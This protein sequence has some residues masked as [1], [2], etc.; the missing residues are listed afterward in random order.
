[1][2][3]LLREVIELPERAG[4]ED[5]VLRL[6]DGVDPAH[7]ARTLDDYVVTPALADSFDAAL[8]LVADAIRTDV[9]RG[10]FLTGSFGSGKSHF[11]AVLHALLRQ[12][13]R[14]RAI[15]DLQQVIARNDPALQTRKIL[16]LAFHF[17]AAESMEQALFDGYLAQ[18]RALHPGCPLPAL[19][20]SHQLFVDA[21]RMRQ[22]LGDERFFEQLNA[23]A[24]DADDAWGA[25]LGAST[26]DADRFDAARAAAPGDPSRQEL[27]TV[28][29]DRFFTTYTRVAS[30]VDLDTGLAA[31]SAHA[32]S[33]GYD[34]VA[35][36]CDEVVLWLAFAV[37]EVDFFR[38]ESQ[39]L[40]KL[41]EGG[42]GVRPIPL[43]SFVARQMDL[44]RWF[45]DSGASGAQQEALDQAFRH[46][47]GRFARIELGDDNLAFV[48]SRRLLRPRDD[49]AR[50]VLDEAFAGLDRRPGV[51]D[52]LLDGVNTDDQHRGADEVAFRR[53]YPFSPALV[54]TLRSLASV[55][56]RERT[57][58]K[59]MQ[60]LLVDRRDVLTV[61][62]VVPVGD[63]F[64]YVVRGQS[65][66]ALDAQAAALFRS[67]DKLY[68]EKLR[69]LLLERY[70]LTESQ[71]SDGAPTP[72]GLAADERLAK[73]LL[74]SAVAPNVPALKGLDA[75]RLAALNHGS[76]ISP[77]PNNEATMVAAK[78]REWARQVPEIRIEADTRNPIIRVVL[79]DVDYESIV[80][81]ARGEDNEGRR[82]ELIKDLVAESLGVDLGQPDALGA[83]LHR[84][85]WRGSVR[86]VY[87]VFGN[88]R[89][90]GWLTDDH[91]RQP[92]G[93]AW[94][95]VIDHPFDEAGH[96]AAEDVERVDRLIASNLTA[97][98]V[99][100]IPRFF[101]EERMRDVRR[102]VILNW[103]LDGSGERY[104]GYADHLSE[105]D[106]VQARAIL[107][108]Q[109]TSLKH[110]LQRAVQVA[111]DAGTPGRGEDVLLDG[112]HDRVLTS[113]DR[114]F[115]PQPPVAATLAGAFTSLLTQA[116]DATFPGHPQFEPG[117][118]EVKKR[119][120]AAVNHHVQRA[121]ADPDG[122]APL[123]GADIAAVRRIANPL[124]VGWA[125]E[126]HFVMGD[127]RFAQWGPAFERALGARGEDP[128]A[129]VT[130]QDL[131][132]WIDAITPAKGLKPEVSDV[133]VLAW[134]GLRQRAWYAHGAPIPAPQP[135][136]LRPEW[137]L[138]VQPMPSAQEWRAATEKAAALFGVA[139]GAFMTPAEVAS[140]AQRVKDAVQ[141][142][143]QP[144]YRLVA[145]L[146]DAR[147]KLGLG[148]PPAVGRSATAEATAVL[149]EHL[150][151]LGGVE[152]IRR[153][154]AE[155]VVNPTAAGRSLASAGEVAT[156]LAGFDHTRLQP[157]RQARGAG[158][159]AGEAAGRILAALEAAMDDDEFT[160]SI[161]TALRSAVDGVFGWLR[162]QV[163]P[164]PPPGPGPQPP[165]PPAASGRRRVRAGESLAGVQAELEAFRTAHADQELTVEWRAGE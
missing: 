121:L 64:D 31:I 39:K 126:T 124:G 68:T 56:Q 113:L 125:A 71:L 120:L 161:R 101:S 109:R 130:V 74:L 51:W 22:S 70:G 119:E 47:E 145:A 97:Q 17:L 32:Q 108:S 75:A 24:D 127:D 159:P 147:T 88:V 128:S 55:M 115:N 89:D 151:H 154:A 13:P 165:R 138:R 98:T 5:Y 6:T 21:A 81:R 10:A 9:S 48:A 34:A 153:L 79:A 87:L 135:G 132:T 136:D 37:R 129:P 114:S 73:T 8:N 4:A 78:V 85:T 52:V 142:A 27:V 137:E 149:C 2:S 41:V 139:A 61:D 14:A 40:T 67:A 158:T 59:V 82:R 143:Y 156:E 15:A 123:E 63:A 65:G 69:P 107:E 144:A 91:F 134:A 141:T 122:R 33:L 50:A 83:H 160:T 77:L 12:D 44:R 116:F 1:M 99:V 117:D 11:M 58:L 93:G 86:E 96:S 19:H 23:G 66:Q 94:R 152:L 95:F 49:T 90:T 118:V 133:V 18:I 131:R 54:S 104:A 57:A 112:T 43:V 92:R 7:I 36:F 28:L 110:A 80:E 3:T 103:L 30:Y 62:D 140:F 100:W 84:F 105:T 106:R 45:A 111:Y 29:A 53:T 42:R 76:I 46:Q 146:G 155:P 25:F 163:P 60:Q 102:L 164:P 38:R 162:D 20:E 72:T 148:E 157:L 35:L 150:R 26:W 16:P